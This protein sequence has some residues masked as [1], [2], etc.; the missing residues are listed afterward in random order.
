MNKMNSEIKRN[1]ILDHYQNPRNKGL[2][3]NKDYKTINMNNESCIDEVNLEIKVENGIIKD[4]KFDGE[5]CAIC[6]SSS[7]IM[8][9]TLIGKTTEEA[10]KI[11][12]NFLNMLDEKP[13]D[14]EILE[15]AIVYDD[16]H[17][18]PNRKKCALLSWWGIE[19]LLNE[20]EAQK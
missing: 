14:K 13:Y 12:Q 6:T 4:I 10:K 1:I 7:S 2:T 19:K 11:L 16:I 3:G 15:E 9:D 20:L 8:T 5:A 18:Q 17:K